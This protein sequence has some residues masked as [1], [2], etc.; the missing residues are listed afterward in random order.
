[1]SST[2]AVAEQAR[3]GADR[4]GP[5][6]DLARAGAAG[7]DLGADGLGALAAG[8]VVRDDDVVGK[9]RRD[10][11]HD[12]PLALVAVAAA[13]E[14]AHDPAGR[15]GAQ[16]LE[17]GLQ[18]IRLVRVVDDDEAAAHPAHDLEPALHALQLGERGQDAGGGLAGGD[19]EA[20]REQR[21][22]RLVVAGQG[23]ADVVAL[24]AVRDAQALREAVAGERLELQ[25]LSAA[26]DGQDGAPA[27][28]RRRDHLRGMLG[29]GIDDGGP[30]G[31]QQLGEQ[32]Q[33]GG[34]IGL[35]AGVIVEMVAAQIGE[36]RGL[37]PDAVEPVLVEA[38]R[39]GLEGQV[40]DAL[41]RQLR[42]RPVQA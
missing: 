37:Q 28:A 18:R 7:Q 26:A 16:R 32:A 29:I 22:R 5:V 15:E 19:G 25:R 2:I 11:P 41:G 14:H 34:E 24:A 1:M 6:A 23:Q 3:A 31:R 4:L 39:G 40:R 8:V 38:V 42:Q 30:V 10:A 27:V 9:A 13:A 21:V 33:L 36:G 17:R 12:R 20:G 35:H